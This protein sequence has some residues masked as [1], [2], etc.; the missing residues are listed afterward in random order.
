MRKVKP[1]RWHIDY[2]LDAPG[3]RVVGV[4]RSRRG[5]C[6]LNRATA[7]RVLDVGFGASDCRAHC[8]AHLKYVGR[9][10]ARR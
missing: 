9:R 4:V 3:V 5:E 2:L 7:G 6:A 8:G 1:L 10:A